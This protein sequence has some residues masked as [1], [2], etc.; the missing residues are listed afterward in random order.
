M[1]LINNREV[2]QLLAMKN[3]LEALE[4]AYEDLLKGGA[5]YKAAVGYVGSLWKTGWR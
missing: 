3:C 5:V 4:I 1:L 2:E